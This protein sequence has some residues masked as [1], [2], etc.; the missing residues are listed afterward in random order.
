MVVAPA[1]LLSRREPPQLPPLPLLPPLACCWLNRCC[2]S[3]LGWVHQP[4]AVA[5]VLPFESA[6]K[7]GVPSKQ[8]ASLDRPPVW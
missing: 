1:Q 8:G 5:A 2:C 7:P 3:Q 6:V 4:W